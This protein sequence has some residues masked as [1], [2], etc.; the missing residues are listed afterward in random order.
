M[1]TQ[2][3]EDGHGGGI[4]ILE[5][6]SETAPM[7][8]R[9]ILPKGLGPPAAEYH[10]SQPRTSASCA[11]RSTSGRSTASACSSARAT[12]IISPPARTTSP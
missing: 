4:T 8:F 5:P 2:T 1:T 11:A 12:P 3:Y 9:M 6:G 10:P 7:R